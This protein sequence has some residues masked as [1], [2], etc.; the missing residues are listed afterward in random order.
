[1]VKYEVAKRTLKLYGWVRSLLQVYSSLKARRF[2]YAIR[3]ELAASDGT[4]TLDLN[5]AEGQRF[6]KASREQFREVFIY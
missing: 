2:N 1:M 3:V 5:S 4:F 6:L